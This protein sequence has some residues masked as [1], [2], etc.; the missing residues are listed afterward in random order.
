[1]TRLPR[2]AAC[3]LILALLALFVSPVAEAQNP[4]QLVT[5]L[6][7]ALTNQP[8]QYN[9]G[10]QL[11]LNFD[12]WSK[13]CSQN[14]PVIAAAIALIDNPVTAN[15]NMYNWWS[16]FLDC[17]NNAASCPHATSLRFFKGGELL[18]STYDWSVVTSV[19]AVNYEARRT[20][21]IWLADK[22]RLYLRKNWVLY[23]LAA[24][25]GP[26]RQLRHDNQPNAAGHPECP[27]N[28]GTGLFLKPCQINAVGQLVYD[29]P[30]LALAGARSGHSHVCQDHRGP[31]LVRA[32]DYPI[33]VN[34]RESIPQAAVLDFIESQWGFFGLSEN[35]YALTLSDRNLIKDHIANENQVGTFLFVLNNSGTRFASE[36]H[37]FA[38]PN[39]R[40]SVLERNLS[41]NTPGC[42]YAIKH[43]DTT[44][45]AHFLHP[46]NPQASQGY[47]VG[48][49][50]LLPNEWSP[51]SVEGRN[52][53]PNHPDDAFKGPSGHQC[54]DVTVSMSVPAGIPSYHVVV[55]PSFDAHQM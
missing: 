42:V 6:H 40:M 54:G 20:G 3:L 13:G 48:Y 11:N 16:T 14:L 1:M 45:E 15:W 25:S 12:C 50:R 17:Q 32:I 38:W 10:S 29:G 8:Y 52:F 41:H 5:D 53:D 34:K 37:F 2:P 18:S 23:A 51:T 28:G 46:W 33:T 21:Q 44:D 36:M 24:G 19:V 27:V 49:G 43:D 55:G 22:A 7:N 4:D 26:A 30:F 35:P 39:A 31:L 9:W 47:R